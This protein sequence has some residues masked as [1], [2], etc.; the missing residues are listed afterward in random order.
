MDTHASVQFL[1]VDTETELE[2]EIEG[3]DFVRS[4]IPDGIKGPKFGVFL[5]LFPDKASIETSHH[6][7][8]TILMQFP[9]NVAP[10]SIST[11]NK[12]FLTQEPS[13]SMVSYMKDGDFEVTVLKNCELELSFFVGTLGIDFTIED[14]D[15]MCL[16]SQVRVQKSFL[17]HGIENADDDDDEPHKDP[18]ANLEED[19][20]LD[21][22]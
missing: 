20:D 14:P 6:N 12:M 1:F 15:D 17:I 7:A 9:L 10:L 13:I 5:Q 19:V 11:G 8:L 18:V 4:A 16:P 21:L 3:S 2:A 22:P